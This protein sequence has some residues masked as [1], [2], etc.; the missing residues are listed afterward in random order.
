MFEDDK[1]DMYN[2]LNE[3]DK[4][5]ITTVTQAMFGYCQDNPYK[6]PLKQITSSE[7]MKLGLTE[8][9]SYNKVQRMKSRKTSEAVPMR[10]HNILAPKNVEKRTNL[11]RFLNDDRISTV[12]DRTGDVLTINGVEERLRFLNQSVLA[13]FLKYKFE[14]NDAMSESVFRKEL[15]RLR[16]I[17]TNRRERLTAL[18]RICTQSS[19]YKKSIDAYSS[20]DFQDFMMET[21]GMHWWNL[22]YCY[23]LTEDCY[24][25]KCTTCGNKNRHIFF[26]NRVNWFGRP[27]TFRQGEF[28]IQTWKKIEGVWKTVRKDGSFQ[29][30]LPEICQFINETK[31]ANHERNRK[32]Q[33]Y[34]FNYLKGYDYDTRQTTTIVKRDH[35]YIRFDHGMRRG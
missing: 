30:C 35:I 15:L 1:K 6:K 2:K 11:E 19:S 23:P 27:E 24:S 22:F 10:S 20:H 14:T 12:S 25:H 18:C 4:G 28:T 5:R 9:Q 7:L 32:N 21:E 3:K 17:K 8:K 26:I 13:S 16:Y 34:F 31:I 29:E 33:G